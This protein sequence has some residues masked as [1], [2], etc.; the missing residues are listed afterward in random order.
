MQGTPLSLIAAIGSILSL[1][2]SVQTFQALPVWLKLF[3][4]F[5]AALLLAVELVSRVYKWRTARRWQRSALK[6]LIVFVAVAL[7][8]LVVGLGGA[9]FA[10]WIVTGSVVHTERESGTDGRTV[11]IH[12]AQFPPATS[13]R[14]YLKPGSQKSCGP[15]SDG[16]PPKATVVKESWSDTTYQP[17]LSIF[18]L[19]SPR[20]VG[21]ACL[22]PVEIQ[23]VEQTPDT[24][25]YM[26]PE[27]LVLYGDVI[28]AIGG[29]FFVILLGGIGLV[30]WRY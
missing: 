6:G 21:L 28:W 26:E 2:L 15:I 11:W 3:A 1:F 4:I 13:I 19:E 30:F 16:R 8:A 23:R 25:Q 27:R 18:N 22:G 17:A 29:A 5:V 9:W 20:K 10:S 24:I 12:N 14:V 7:A